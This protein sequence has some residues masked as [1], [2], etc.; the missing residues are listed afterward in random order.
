MGKKKIEKMGIRTNVKSNKWE[1]K[2]CCPDFFAISSR[3]CALISHRV[4]FAKTAH[5]LLLALVNCIQM[6]DFSQSHYFLNE[7]K[8]AVWFNLLPLPAS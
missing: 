4:R 5:C 3:A 1:F 2:K 8:N 7:R 6:L